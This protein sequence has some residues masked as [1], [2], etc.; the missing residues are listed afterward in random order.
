MF[1]ASVRIEVG[2]GSRIRF[3]EDP[4]IGGWTASAIA[5][6]VYELVAAGATCRRTVQSGMVNNAWTGD[7]RGALTV[8]ATVQYLALWAAIAEVH[9]GEGMDMFVWKWT[10][11]DL[12]KSRSAY[13]AF[14]HGSTGMPGAANVWSA[15][16]PLKLKL[17]A[18]L[19]LRDRCWTASRRLRRGL[20]SHTLCPLCGLA[21]ETM[22]HLT[23]G[24]AFSAQ[25][26]AGL[27]SRT[28]IPLV[29]PTPTE[30]KLW[31]PDVVLGLPTQTRNSLIMLG[32]W[33]IWLERNAR[34]FD[35]K[36]GSAARVTDCAMVELE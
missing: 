14:F 8:D 36:S 18:W 4:W 2:D 1:N 33:T 15:F 12:F 32:L 3:W 26:W 25:M 28:G 22:D 17:H 6:T 35:N 11:D 9:M 5:P 10:A 23:V 30:L 31:W 34:V 24:C 20:P 29:A 13:R 7:I 19:A 21:D 27:F 16:A